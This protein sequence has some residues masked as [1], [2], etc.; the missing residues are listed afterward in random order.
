MRRLRTQHCSLRALR[1]HLKLWASWTLHSAIAKKQNRRSSKSSRTVPSGGNKDTSHGRKMSQPP[2][3]N[4][5]RPAPHHPV[6]GNM[7]TEGLSAAGRS[8]KKSKKKR[9]ELLSLDCIHCC[10]GPIN[11]DTR[12]FLEGLGFSVRGGSVKLKEFRCVHFRFWQCQKRC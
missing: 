5:G 10:Q 1:A 3:V 9:V 6:P 11:V 8:Q 2:V 7:S 12:F 4:G